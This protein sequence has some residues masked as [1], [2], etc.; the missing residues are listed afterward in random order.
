MTLTNK[1]FKYYFFA[2]LSTAL[3]TI[4]Y[5][6]NVK[7]NNIQYACI[8]LTLIVF[9]FAIY[10]HKPVIILSKYLRTSCPNIY[11]NHIGFRFTGRD[12][13]AIID[14]AK[15]KTDELNQIQDAKIIELIYNLRA[16]RK[17][18]LISFVFTLAFLIVF[19][20]YI[21]LN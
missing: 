6:L 2:Q 13:L 12:N 9:I 19:S 10:Y 16:S 20:V 18:A 3:I 14:A 15:I 1:R 5:I 7:W 21:K 4:F 8:G 11:R 17:V